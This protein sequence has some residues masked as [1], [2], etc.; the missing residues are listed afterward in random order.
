MHIE[1]MAL[2]EKKLTGLQEVISQL[3]DNIL[4]DPDHDNDTINWALD[5]IDDAMT[6]AP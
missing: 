5:L 6:Q 1:E 4:H 3:R 2:V